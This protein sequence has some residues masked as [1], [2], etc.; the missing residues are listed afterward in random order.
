MNKKER[1]ANAILAEARIIG[2]FVAN[3]LKSS[4]KYESP[5]TVITPSPKKT[6][7]PMVFNK[8]AQ[9]FDYL[10]V[11]KLGK[12]NYRL[13]GVIG[14][15]RMDVDKRFKSITKAKEYMARHLKN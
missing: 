6:V 12:G 8:P 1:K 14:G 11:F 5:A 15:I 4:V 9:M 7:T 2:K 13:E 3:N 10:R